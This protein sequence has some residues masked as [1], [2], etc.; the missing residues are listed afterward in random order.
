M[1]FSEL[2]IKRESC[3]DYC[4]KKVPREKLVALIDAARLSP[5]ACNSQPWR[6]IVVDDSDKTEKLKEYLY[7]EKSGTNRHA[8]QVPAFI[9]EIETHAKLKQ[10]AEE[11][12]GTQHYAQ[13]D[14]GSVTA[15][16]TLKAADMGLSTCIMGVFD[17]E[18]VKK[19]LSIPDEL[20]IRLIIAVG[21]SKTPDIH[22]KKRKNLEDIVSYNQF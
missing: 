7:D 3:R 11:L 15:Y 21:Y 5:S 14:I 12:Y 16:L 4:D 6:F 18:K 13:M 2:I 1:E 20:K 19:L 8:F 17:E 9:V 22:P 10:R